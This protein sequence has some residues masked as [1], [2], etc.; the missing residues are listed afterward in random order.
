MN[1]SK[2]LDTIKEGLGF[3]DIVMNLNLDE[4]SLLY[5]ENDSERTIQKWLGTF[6]AINEKDMREEI[7]NI[8]IHTI[9]CWAAIQTIGSNGLCDECDA[10]SQM[11]IDLFTDIFNVKEGPTPED[12]Q[13]YPELYDGNDLKDWIV[14]Q[15]LGDIEVREEIQE[16]FS[17]EHPYLILHNVH[18]VTDVFIKEKYRGRNIG[19]AMIAFMLREM[20]SSPSDLFVAYPWPFSCEDTYPDREFTEN[21]IAEAVRKNELYFQNIG[22]KVV[23]DITHNRRD[24]N[25]HAISGEDALMLLDI[26][27]NLT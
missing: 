7:G 10:H 25:L 2:L 20:S 8:T 18:L 16:L 14:F 21:E 27:N 5:G 24:R 9:R 17:S 15:D 4:T 13:R 23:R 3:D 6:I 22:F 19:H 11:M 1:Y 26:S 12:V